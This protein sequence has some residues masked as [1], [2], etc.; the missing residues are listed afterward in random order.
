MGAI[1]CA[2]YVALCVA[3]NP[4][5]FGALQLRVATLLL[6]L[7]FR[8]KRFANGLILGVIIANMTS[9]LG[10]IDVFVGLMIQ[11]TIYYIFPLFIKN[12]W[13]HGIAYAILSGALVGAELYITLGVPFM[14]SWVTVGISGLVLYEL[15][16]LLCD[17]LMR[18]IDK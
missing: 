4:I 5:S 2:M 1:V 7:G 13:I 9:S 10:M 3:L 17:K 8:D 14:Y 6:P 18:Y 11:F 15:G 12:K 16:N